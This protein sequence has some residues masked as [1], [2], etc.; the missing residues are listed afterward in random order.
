MQL[1]SVAPMLFCASLYCLRICWLGYK[2][3]I[4]R[5]LKHCGQ[6]GVHPPEYLC[7]FSQRVVYPWALCAIYTRG[8]D[9][10]IW[11]LSLKVG[12]ACI[13]VAR[14]DS[15]QCSAAIVLLES[16]LARR[17]SPPRYAAAR[18]SALDWL[19]SGP[20]FA[21]VPSC[22]CYSHYRSMARDRQF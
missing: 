22:A 11:R 21:F 13:A 2:K 19:E 15:S 20:S 16:S 5:C 9:N 3:G 6:W 18:R 10:C 7:P 4:C 1:Y 8:R 17:P 12:Y 14:L